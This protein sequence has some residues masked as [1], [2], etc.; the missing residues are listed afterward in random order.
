MSRVLID[1]ILNFEPLE[2]DWRELETIFENVFS[3]K[4]PEFYYPAIFGL[5]KNILAKTERVCFGQ[6]FMEWK[7][8]EI[9]RLNC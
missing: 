8:L 6:L 5:L 4:N 2:G 7:E 3:S 1:R 9:M